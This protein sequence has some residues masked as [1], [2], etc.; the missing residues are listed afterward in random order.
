MK[1]EE[2][3]KNLCDDEKNRIAELQ[4][5]NTLCLPHLRSA[6]PMELS[7]SKQGE[8]EDALETTIREGAE[9]FSSTRTSRV[10]TT[11]LKRKINEEPVAPSFKKT[12]RL[13]P[14]P[15]IV[16]PPASTKEEEVDETDGSK[17]P[18]ESF[19]ITFSPPKKTKSKPPPRLTRSNGSSHLSTKSSSALEINTSK[20]PSVTKK[21]SSTGELKNSG[22]NS[23]S[24]RSGKASTAAPLDGKTNS[25]RLTQTLRKPLPSDTKGS[26]APKRAKKPLKEETGNKPAS[27]NDDTVDTSVKTAGRVNEKFSRTDV[28]RSSFSKAKTRVA[29]SLRGKK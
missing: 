22:T 5:R 27:K 19:E 24:G 8:Q 20:A 3:K 26:L 1:T 21:A 4:R 13:V 16:E 23:L 6:Y 29:A 28:K 10:E 11:N 9:T 12:K 2:K 15:L 25:R 18:A 17:K 7:V 14:A